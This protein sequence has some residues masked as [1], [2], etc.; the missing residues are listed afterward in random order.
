M[1][2]ATALYREAVIPP[3]LA[4]VHVYVKRHTASQAQLRVLALTDDEPGALLE[5]QEGFTEL[6]HAD[7]LV[8][9]SVLFIDFMCLLYLL[10]L[11]SVSL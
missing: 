10:Y 3:F 8:E 6:A 11:L 7:E 9:V 4:R 2:T 1:G 5:V